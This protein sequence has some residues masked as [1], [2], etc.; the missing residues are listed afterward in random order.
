MYTKPN[1]YK[2]CSKMIFD[3]MN[4]GATI[5]KKKILTERTKS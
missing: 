1:T 2:C 4:G 3:S 5:A